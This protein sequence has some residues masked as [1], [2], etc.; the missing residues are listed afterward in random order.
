LKEINLIEMSSKERNDAMNEVRL[1]SMLDHKNIISYYDSFILN[2]SLN[3]VMEYANAGDIHLEIKKRTLQNKTFSEFEI[4]SWFT[5]IC[6]AIQ[7]I[8]TKNILHRDLKTQ[9]IFLSIVDGNYYIKIG[10]FGIAK[11]L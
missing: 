8:F 9:N 4:L 6:E 7:F 5:Q 11:I 1:L 10:D 3:I 2:G